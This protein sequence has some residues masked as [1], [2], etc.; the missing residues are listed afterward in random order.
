LTDLQRRA[1]HFLKRW[2]APCSIGLSFKHF[3]LRVKRVEFV[4]FIVSGRIFF[5]SV[6]VAILTICTRSQGS[7]PVAVAGTVEKAPLIGGQFA[8]HYLRAERTGAIVAGLRD[9][10]ALLPVRLPAK[11]I[12][13]ATQTGRRDV[14]GLQLLDVDGVLP[15]RWAQPA[16]WGFFLKGPGAYSGFGRDAQR[17]DFAGIPFE[18]L[19]AYERDNGIE[20][21]V[22]RRGSATVPEAPPLKVRE[23]GITRAGVAIHWD[24]IAGIKYQLLMSLTP[25]GPYR[26][27]D[28]IMPLEDGDQTFTITFNG[29]VGFFRITVS[30]P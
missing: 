11:V 23:V 28:E 6:L 8:T 4:R 3:L 12:L 24:A 15:E 2:L 19:R 9:P 30:E 18:E 29:T 13:Q 27:V 21:A 17:K 10:R 14:S 1:Q 20:G 16:S 7:E 25:E 5:L 26:P 22:V